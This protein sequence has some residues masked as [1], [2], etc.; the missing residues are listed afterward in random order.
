[1]SERER[2]QLRS[3][4][5]QSYEA[6]ETPLLASDPEKRKLAL[7]SIVADVLG[8][9]R[10]EKFF[11]DLNLRE[12]QKAE[13]QLDLEVFTLSRRLSLSPLQ[14]EQLRQ[15]LAEANKRSAP[16]TR[17]LASR[18]EQA[19]ALHFDGDPERAEL[20]TQY[21]QI[22]E[23]K[24]SVKQEKNS[25]VKENLKDQLSDEQLNKLIELQSDGSIAN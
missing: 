14:E 2:E 21:E 6:P 7:K 23:L 13:E 5:A 9:D 17:E 8:A 12:T 16:L 24:E 18:M 15:A 4:L 11:S 20:R 19:M 22:R 1:L 25:V 10:A 3:R